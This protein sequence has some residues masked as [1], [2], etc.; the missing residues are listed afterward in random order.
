[1][2][3]RA[4][5]A[6][7]FAWLPGSWDADRDGVLEGVQHNTYD[8]EFYGPNPQCG[9]Y[10]LGALRAAEEMA[11]AQGDSAFA[12]QCRSLFERGSKWMDANLFN[13][14]F[15]IQKVQP[16]SRPTV[17]R[18]WCPTWA[19]TRVSRPNI[20]SAMAA[21]WINWSASIRPKCAVW[22]HC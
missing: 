20:R 16:H 6:L 3:P 14:E 15:Y 9:I 18:A 1:M 4:R 7:E 8:V 17:P 11:R 2:W 5:R 22:V 13:G 19:P 21:W 12:T 10:Y